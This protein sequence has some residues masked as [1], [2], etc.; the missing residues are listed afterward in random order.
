LLQEGEDLLERGCVSHNY[1]EFYHLGIEV[2]LGIGDASRALR[3][4]AQL[5]A[6]TRDEPVPWADLVI[7]R[8][9]ALAAAANAA[10]GAGELLRDAL[11]ATHDMQWDDLLPGLL[12]ATSSRA[13]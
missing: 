12:Q 2:A 11:A 5:E 8:G 10:P 3:Y 4:A 9:R 13:R 7:A 6:Y 1:L